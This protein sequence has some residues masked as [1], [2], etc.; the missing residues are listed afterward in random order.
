MIIHAGQTLVL[1]SEARDQT[2]AGISAYAAGFTHVFV[3]SITAFAQ[4]TSSF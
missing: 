4:V 2:V 1:Q 3:I